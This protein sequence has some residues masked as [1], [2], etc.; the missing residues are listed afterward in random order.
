M[1]EIN[2]LIVYKNC[3]LKNIY[4]MLLSIYGEKQICPLQFYTSDD[5]KI[6]RAYMLMWTYWK[7]V[8]ELW[9]E[10]THIKKG[11]WVW[12]F[13]GLIVSLPHVRVNDSIYFFHLHWRVFTSFGE[14]P[15]LGQ[16]LG[17]LL[18]PITTERAILSRLA[19]QINPIQDFIN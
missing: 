14:F 13:P 15:I 6:P 3:R 5:S 4:A 12:G 19:T 16:S 10:P 9:K 8:P 2:F 18:R 17:L 7:S 11:P 1:T